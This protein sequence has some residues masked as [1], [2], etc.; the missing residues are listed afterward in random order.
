MQERRILIG[1]VS[2]AFGVSGELR[3]QS[4][5][6]PAAQLLRYRPV[7]LSHG[8]SERTLDAL[9]GR[10]TPR[11]VV[12]RLPEV[13]DRDSAQAMQGAELWVKRSQ[14]PKPAPGEYYWVDL[15]GLRV[16]NREGVDFGTVSHLFQTPANPVL[17]VAGERERLIPFLLDRFVDAVDFDIGEIRVD[18]DADF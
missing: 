13:T 6:E 4:F 15:E 12:L 16:V 5:T 10:G 3:C 14:L 8:G 18:W 7:I 1:R 2:G 17:V 11:G 9:Q